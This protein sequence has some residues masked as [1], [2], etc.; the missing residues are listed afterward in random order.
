MWY[1]EVTSNFYFCDPGHASNRELTVRECAAT[2]NF[3]VEHIF[4]EFSMESTSMSSIPTSM[5]KDLYL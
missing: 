3:F 2:L 1:P 4:F 5:D